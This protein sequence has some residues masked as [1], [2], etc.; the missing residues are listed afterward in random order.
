[1]LGS[2]DKYSL[3]TPEAPDEPPTMSVE[4]ALKLECNISINT[5]FLM[6]GILDVRYSVRMSLTTRASTSRLRR[7]APR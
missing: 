6:S 2:A 3:S 7:T 5:N 4:K 1:M